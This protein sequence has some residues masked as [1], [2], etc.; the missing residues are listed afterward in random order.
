[1]IQEHG[2]LVFD[3]AII[4]S[5]G[6][7][8]GQ[9][10]IELMKYPEN[11]PLIDSRIVSNKTFNYLGLYNESS[12][13]YVD[14]SNTKP[15]PQSVISAIHEAGGKAVVAHWGRY[16]LSNEDVF[17]WTTPNGKA[18]LEEIIDMCDGAECSYPDNPIDLRRMIY[19]MCKEK[20][21]L[22]SIGGD[23]HGKSGKEGPQY[24]LGSQ[25]GKEVEELKWIKKSVIEGHEFTRMLEEEHHYK[26]RLQEII[27]EKVALEKIALGKLKEEKGEISEQDYRDN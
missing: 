10:Y 24:Q 20:G 21:K 23:N 11:K 19:N 12:P 27:G 18:N 26:R 22:V 17:D 6:G 1:M 13:F 5:A 9:F 14:L 2:D 3:T 16:K 15:S 4:Q 8:A 25:K 7:A